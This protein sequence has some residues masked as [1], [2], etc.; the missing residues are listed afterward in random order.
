MF[1]EYYWNGYFDSNSCFLPNRMLNGGNIDNFLGLR[2]YLQI[3][4]ITLTLA[5]NVNGKAFRNMIMRS[6]CFIFSFVVGPAH[7]WSEQKEQVHL[8]KKAEAS[9]NRGIR[10]SPPASAIAPAARNT[11]APSPKPHSGRYGS[12]HTAASTAGLPSLPRLTQCEGKYQRMSRAAWLNCCHTTLMTFDFWAG[13]RQKQ[14]NKPI[15]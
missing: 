13:V 14:T 1:L 10:T 9:L 12:F 2:I 8:R 5:Q 11:A 4:A 7:I 3:T 6:K 15:H